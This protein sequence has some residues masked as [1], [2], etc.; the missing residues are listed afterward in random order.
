MGLLFRNSDWPPQ[1]GPLT[2]P[3]THSKTASGL[4][5]IS[6]RDGIGPLT[7]PPTFAG[8]PPG[9]GAWVLAHPRNGP[10]PFWFPAPR[11]DDFPLTRGNSRLR[12]GGLKE[13]SR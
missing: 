13:V 6:L 8:S 9:T 7:H 1:I 11:M 10:R 12:L 5:E 4:L 2:H 3:Q